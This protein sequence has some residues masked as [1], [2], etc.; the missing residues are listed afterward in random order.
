M[1]EPGLKPRQTGFLND[2]LKL[3]LLV[4]ER[5]VFRNSLPLR[6]EPVMRDVRPVK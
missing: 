6:M 5:A 1:P 2:G 4:A 3:V